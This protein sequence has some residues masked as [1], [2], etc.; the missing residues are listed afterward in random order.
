[1]TGGANWPEFGEIDIFENVNLAT[2]NAYSLHTEDGCNAS[3]LVAM[4]GDLVSTVCFNETNFDEGCKVVD[5]ST[6]SFGQDFASSGGGAFAMLWN[7]EGI[8][9]W[10]FTR[11]AIP[12]DLPTMNP[13]PS[14]WGT[15][16]AFYPSSTCNFT[17]FFGPQTMILVEQLQAFFQLFLSTHKLF[18]N[19]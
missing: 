19:L 7:N 6:N 12:S 10:F 14:G 15:P 2:N 17:E 5:N 13:N 18:W 16:T 11:S 4:T 9:I 8:Q 1:M 3:S